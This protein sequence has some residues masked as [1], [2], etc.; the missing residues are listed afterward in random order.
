MPARIS[1]TDRQRAE[2]LALPTSEE[3]VVRHYS[4][5]EYDL[6]TIA[7]SRSPANRLGYALQLCC[8]RYPG[9]YLRRD[10]LLPAV[11]LDYVA[12][13]VAVD[14]DIIAEFARRDPTRYEQLAAMKRDHGFRDL[15]QPLRTELGAWLDAEAPTTVDGRILLDRLVGKMRADHIIIPGVSVIER[16]TASAL[17]RAE[18]GMA[19]LIHDQFDPATKERLEAI[20]AEKVHDQQ[21]RLSWLRAP[22]NRVSA[23]SLAELLDKIDMIQ[24]LGLNAIVVPTE[25][26]ARLNQLAREGVRLTAQ[27]LQQMTPP[28]RMATLV[29]TMRE[30][31]ATITDAALA[32]F[33]SLVG[34]ANLRARKRLD[35]TI[36]ASADQGRERLV[37]IA[38]V[39]EAMTKAMRNNTDVASAVIAVAS[40][41]LIEADAALIR[42]STKPGRLDVVGELEPEYRVFKQIGS[43]FLATFSFEGRKPMAVLQTAI[44]ILVE[45]GGSWRKPLP[46]DIPLGHIERRWGRH[47]IADGKVDRTYWELATYFAVS[48]A[49]AAGD[50]WVPTSRIHRALED[51][52]NP[53]VTPL[54]G[55]ARVLSDRGTPDFDQWIAEKFTQLD[56]A[57]LGTMRGL[58]TKDAALFRS[59][60]RRVGKEC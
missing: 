16:L 41:D 36:L 29:A 33:N 46:L 56:Q 53:A 26:R 31:E 20:L 43:R 39:L 48:S 38:A 58:S 59:E 9:R 6:A 47:L 44:A 13:Q 50:L 10:E 57:L 27:A 18:K 4:L 55:Q 5:S 23:R 52:I 28:R 22:P 51:L 49:L 32:M 15:T 54:A 35:E 12:E 7:K 1:M 21:S 19:T 60:E 2:V 37:R 34:R 3:E 17:H 8:L 40:I 45:L 30:L 25:F 24:N 42:R 14:A 11:M